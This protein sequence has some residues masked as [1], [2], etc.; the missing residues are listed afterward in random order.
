MS[1]VVLCEACGSNRVVD[2]PFYDRNHRVCWDCGYQSTASE[3]FYEETITE[4]A[5]RA[6]EQVT[7]TIEEFPAEGFKTPAE[8]EAYLKKLEKQTKQLMGN[9]KPRAKKS[10][11]TPVPTPAQ[12]DIENDLIWMGIHVYMRRG[13]SWTDTLREAR[14][15]VQFRNDNVRVF[16]HEHS[17]GM[18]CS[19]KCREINRKQSD[20]DAN[21]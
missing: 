6:E 18:E 14:E 4:K 12:T 19:P 10:A 15:E 11:P 8:A 17:Y 5:E 13:A 3:I 2:G 20:D 16:A 21:S 1:D 7:A 9:K